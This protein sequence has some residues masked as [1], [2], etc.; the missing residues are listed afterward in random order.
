MASSVETTIAIALPLQVF[1]IKNSLKLAAHACV[2]RKRIIIIMRRFYIILLTNRSERCA[3]QKQEHSI[4]LILYIQKLTL[5]SWFDA[6]GT[7][8]TLMA[9]TALFSPSSPPLL[10]PSCL[11]RTK[12]TSRSLA[13]VQIFASYLLY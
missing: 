12:S 9:S 6:G 7:L 3:L 10:P 11:P 1:I 13:C 5:E 4:V 2:L 8:E